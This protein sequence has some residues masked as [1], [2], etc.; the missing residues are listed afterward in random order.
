MLTFGNTEWM[1]EK[2][3][4]VIGIHVHAKLGKKFCMDSI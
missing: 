2:A 4:T 1:Y 3:E